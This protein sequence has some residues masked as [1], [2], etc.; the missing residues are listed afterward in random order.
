MAN[1]TLKPEDPITVAELMEVAEEAMI[2]GSIPQPKELSFMGFPKAIAVFPGLGEWWRIAYAVDML[3]KADHRNVK[4][5]F[6]TG[7]N[8]KERTYVCPSLEKLNLGLL[9]NLFTVVVKDEVSQDYT[10]QQAAWL[11]EQL[12][13]RSITSVGLVVSQY[14]TLRAY[15][16]LLKRCLIQGVPVR[17]V[18]LIPR[19]SP[20]DPVPET[21]QPMI[22]RYRPEI[23]RIVQYRRKGDVAN[24]EEFM[25]AIR[26]LWS[27]DDLLRRFVPSLHWSLAAPFAEAART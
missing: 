24:H 12:S 15:L 18:P 2:L 10:P 7:Y 25:A 27:P 26:Q 4:H 21:G 20:F 23:E 22:E 5:L 9:A 3:L 13:S 14:H 1:E 8:C 17:I 6:I 19:V 16:T 11:V